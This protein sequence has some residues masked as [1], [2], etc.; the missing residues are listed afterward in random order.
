[1][2]EKIKSEGNQ[3]FNVPNNDEGKS[4]MELA[5]KYRNNGFHLNCK[6]RGSR[7]DHGD[8]YNIPLEH[9]EWFAVYPVMK[10]E[11]RHGGISDVGFPYVKYMLDNEKKNKTELSVLNN[12]INTLEENLETRGDAL[13]DQKEANK[14]IRI[15]YEKYISSMDAQIEKSKEE[16]GNVWKLVRKKEQEIVNVRG[17]VR[18]QKARIQEDEEVT[19]ILDERIEDLEEG[20]KLK[21]TQIKNNTDLIMELDNN[22]GAT[23]MGIPVNI[24]ENVDSNIVNRLLTI[25][26]NL[27]K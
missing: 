16:N 25:I 12:A 24:S 10:Y 17:I 22:S 6:G 19:K 13:E 26:E 4:F 7:K 21:D 8:S 11:N 2:K 3:L 9:S 18:D 15:N 5:R 14:N 27:T 20:I 1:M 23:H